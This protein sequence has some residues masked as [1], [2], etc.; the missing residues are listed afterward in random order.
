M[1]ADH[2]QDLT[3]PAVGRTAGEGLARGRWRW[4][5]PVVAAAVVLGVGA[6]IY[7]GIHSRSAAERDLARTTTAAAVPTVEVTH[8]KGGAQDVKLLLPGNMQAFND[9]AIYARTSGY[10]KR[11]YVDIGA[12]VKR[13]DLMAEIDTPEVDE[14]LR[15]AQAD[16]AN[17]Q[18]NLELAEVTAQRQSRL[19]T[20]GDAPI[21]QRDNAVSAVNADK[22]TLQ[23]RQAAVSRL[24][25]MQL[26]ER[27]EAPFDGVVTAR[28]ID[29]GALITAGSATSARE[30]FHV[31]ASEWLRI[32]VSVPEI[33]AP[34]VRPGLTPTITLDEFPGETFQGVVARTSNAID[35]TSRTLLVEVDV[36]N[37]DGRLLPGSYAHV[38]FALPTVRKTVTIPVN[39]LL[40]RKE[41]SQVAIVRD[42]KVELVPVKIG[43]DY[44]DSVEIVSGL[45]AADQI[46]VNPADSL[47]S[48]TAVVVNSKAEAASGQPI[49]RSQG[50][51]PVAP[52][53]PGVKRCAR[54]SDI[55]TPTCG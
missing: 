25:E 34:A 43:H 6:A 22:A 45:D 31:V 26:F 32:Y 4:A 29:V 7:A 10:L 8:P 28:T 53:S 36:S 1:P 3:R 9:T 54:K 40:F 18:A 24:E 15:Q 17:A 5:G 33:Y 41:G 52:T 49:A 20:S 12:H 16:L 35:Q 38:L 48:G 2:L 46:V 21:Q 47:V 30:L 11:W 37:K 27:V 23:S 42:G 14:Q 50:A 19:A 55:Q 51:D 39:T 44:G 13:G